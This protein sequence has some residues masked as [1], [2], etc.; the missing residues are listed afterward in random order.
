MTQ[1]TP[2]IILSALTVILSA[3]KDL[4]NVQPKFFA[5]L[6]MTPIRGRK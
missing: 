2:T 3:A 1:S 4:A 5:P 6:K